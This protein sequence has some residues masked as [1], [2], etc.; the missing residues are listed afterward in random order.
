MDLG[1]YIT[2]LCVYS[3][4]WKRWLVTAA[5]E[6]CETSY[7]MCLN[8]LAQYRHSK[9]STSYQSRYH[10]HGQDLQL[11]PVFMALDFPEGHWC[12]LIYAHAHTHT[13]THT[14]TWIH[15][16]TETHISYLKWGLASCGS[17][18]NTRD[19]GWW[20]GQFALFQRLATRGESGLMSNCR[21]LT[22]GVCVYVCEWLVD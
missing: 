14:H 15:T 6:G 9:N 11:G 21:L 7:R 18:T 20:K 2:S 10:L 4:A 13:H 1:T 17:K 22:V 8:Y 16:H 5:S 19:T 12:T 3:V